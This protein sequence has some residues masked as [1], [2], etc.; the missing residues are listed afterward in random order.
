MERILTDRIGPRGVVTLSF[1]VCIVY[2]I[3]DVIVGK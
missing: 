3:V 2:A 1:V